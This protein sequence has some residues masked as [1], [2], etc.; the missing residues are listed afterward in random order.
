MTSAAAT[1]RVPTRQMR[2]VRA[3]RYVT[4]SRTCDNTIEQRLHVGTQAPITNAPAIRDD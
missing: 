2:T 4:D 3:T 1:V